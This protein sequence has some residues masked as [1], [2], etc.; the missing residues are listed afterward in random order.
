M[1]RVVGLMSGSSLDGLD[2]VLI[3]FQDKNWSLLKSDTISLPTDLAKSLATIC[4][5]TAIELAHTQA[6]YSSFL[7]TALKTFM[8]GYS[9]IAVVGI[10]GHTVLHL[11]EIKTSWQLLNGGQVAAE[12]NVPVVCDFRN[13]DMALGGQGT[14]M[15]VIADRDLYPGYDYYINLGGIANISY[16]DGKQWVAYDI[17]PCNQV[18]NYFSSTM[19]LPYDN[20]GNIA[21]SGR[22]NTK[23]LTTLNSTAFFHQ[24]PPKSLDNSWIRN[25]FIKIVADNELSIPDSLRTC[26]EC[27]AL[28]IAESIVTPNA[29][30]LVT[31]GGS[32][33]SYLIQLMKT[34]LVNKN[35]DIIIPDLQTVDYKEAILIAYC[36]LLRLNKEVNFI[37]SAT[38]ASQAV[39]GGALYL[40]Q[41]PTSDA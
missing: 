26:T 3:D 40:G 34:Q 25:D 7:S 20:K 27:I 41:N 14:P 9:N 37:T 28:Q 17:C 30:I 12:I 31:G 38:G 33:N 22:I 29:K 11:P 8:E 4:D 10:H 19:G 36:A 32:K 24:A 18:L 15:A 13:Q 5:Q 6:A 23:L 16:Y 21:K 2:I 1:T 35:S 39:I